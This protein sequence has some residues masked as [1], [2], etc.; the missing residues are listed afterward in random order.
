MERHGPMYRSYGWRHRNFRTNPRR[1]FKELSEWGNAIIRNN[2][3]N[4]VNN[5]DVLPGPDTNT[6]TISS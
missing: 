1:T 3:V 6:I 5:F 2:Q 4:L